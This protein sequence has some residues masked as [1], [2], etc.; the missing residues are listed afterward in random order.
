MNRRTKRKI[1]A[2]LIL[3]LLLS[4]AFG[5]TLVKLAKEATF[6]WFDHTETELKVKAYA[7]ENGLFFADY[8][9]SLIALL[10]RN[11]ETE[12]FVLEYPRYRAEDYDLSGYRDADTV[13]LFLQWDQRWGYETYGSD[14]MAITGCGP[15]C[16]AMVGYYLTGDAKFDPAAVAAFAEE[17]GYYVE[18]SGSSWTLISEGGPQL[19]LDVVEIPLDEN[20]MKEAL[21]HGNPIILAMGPGDFTS[22]GH[23]IVLTGVEDGLFAVNDPNS[24]ERSS[25]LWSYEEIAGQIRNIW[26][27]GGKQYGAMPIGE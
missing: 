3:V 4:T 6:Y 22:S 19:G 2:A 7:E 11:P 21:E 17:N 18:G 24:P 13:P 14:M 16:L 27:I 20:R 10:E 1:A 8:P 12:K 23:Y 26:A 9:E 5:G 15:T 25:K